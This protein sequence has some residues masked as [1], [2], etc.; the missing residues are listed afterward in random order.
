M[1]W[2]EGMTDDSFAVPDAGQAR[3][4]R[5][6]A[7]LSRLTERHGATPAQRERRSHPAALAPYE[8]VS[9]VLA[10]AAGSARPEPGEPAVDGADLTAAL[11]LMPHVRADVDAQEAAL[12]ELARSRGLTWQAIAFGL[13]LGTAQAARQRYERVTGRVR[14]E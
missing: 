3:A 10:L 8:A 2:A 14:P 1:V 12:L 7:A 9:V 5:D 4:S 11:T 6:F 13:G